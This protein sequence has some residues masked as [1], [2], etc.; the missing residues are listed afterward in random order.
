V[1][2]ASPRQKKSKKSQICHAACF[3]TSIPAARFSPHPDPADL[4]SFR[5]NP[6]RHPSVVTLA[7]SSP[8]FIRVHSR[9]NAPSYNMDLPAI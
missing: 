6:E 4:G 5:K 7:Y 2:N 9:P 8:F 3:S 1:H